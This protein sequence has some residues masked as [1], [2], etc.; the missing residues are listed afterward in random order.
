M[1]SVRV[2]RKAVGQIGAQRGGATD[3]YPDRQSDRQMAGTVRVC[4]CVCMHVYVCVC[5]CVCRARGRKYYEHY[6][7]DCV[8][9]TD[10]AWE[11][12]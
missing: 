9:K 2:D 8:S 10:I 11:T 5:V 12:S 4:V 6:L 3:K 7:S 1:D